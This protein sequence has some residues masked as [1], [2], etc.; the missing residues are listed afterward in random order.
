[1][2]TTLK[3]DSLF[4]ELPQNNE[5]IIDRF[6]TSYKKAAKEHDCTFLERNGRDMDI[7]LISSGLFSAVNTAFIIAMQPDPMT[8]LLWQL[9][10][11]TSFNTNITISPLAA[12]AANPPNTIWF[13]TFAYVALSLNLLA[14]FGAVLGKQ[15]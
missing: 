3:Q 8:P 9:V 12:S 5:F 13:Q 10:Q 11:N 2:A 14:A 15:W 6:W 7:I 1:M 4:Q